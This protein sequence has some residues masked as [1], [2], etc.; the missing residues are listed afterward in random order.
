[1]INSVIRQVEIED[2]RKILGDNAKGIYRLDDRERSPQGFGRTRQEIGGQYGKTVAVLNRWRLSG[3]TLN[4]DDASYFT[5]DTIGPMRMDQ[6]DAR[7][8]V[9]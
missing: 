8:T 4:V 9:S 3:A 2:P 6:T 1:M 5:A 7:F